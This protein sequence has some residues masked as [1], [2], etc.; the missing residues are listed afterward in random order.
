[1]SHKKLPL[2]ARVVALRGEHRSDFIS[3]SDLQDLEHLQRLEWTAAKSAALK[4]EEIKTR[5]QHGAEVETGTL[6][7]DADLEMVR[8]H[9]Q[10][11]TITH[12]PEPPKEDAG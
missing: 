12:Q 6:Y 4:S 9:R 11:V 3:Q 7:Y 1:M 10:P 5:I 2:R 8:H